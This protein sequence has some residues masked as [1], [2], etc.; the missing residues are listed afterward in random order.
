MYGLTIV[1]GVDVVPPPLGGHVASPLRGQWVFEVFN[2]E[3]AHRRG[4][5]SEHKKEDQHWIF[6]CSAVFTP[7]CTHSRQSV[8]A[9]TY[10]GDRRRRWKE[11]T[12]DQDA[13]G[14][15]NAQ[16]GFNEVLIF[17]RISQEP[18][19]SSQRRLDTAAAA[20]PQQNCLCSLTGTELPC[21]PEE[22]GRQTLHICY[23]LAGKQEALEEHWENNAEMLFWRLE[24]TRLGLTSPP[25]WSSAKPCRVCFK[26]CKWIPNQSLKA[27]RH[28]V[29]TA[30]S[31]S[32]KNRSPIM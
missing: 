31:H 5:L 14:M 24:R 25:V 4:L 2:R 28:A 20:A 16:L 3:L 8:V 6:S 1:S 23:S 22:H 11:T 13:R 12:E 9:Q 21:T 19:T 18:V 27:W 30:E 17:S 29:H 26:R 10:A 32:Q 7:T 15:C